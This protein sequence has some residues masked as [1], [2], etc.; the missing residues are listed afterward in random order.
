MAQK[1]KLLAPNLTT[2]V[3]CLCSSC[4]KQRAETQ[5]LSTD[6][7]ASSLTTHLKALE[8]K[9]AN[10]P[11]RSRRQEIIKLR[12]ED[13]STFKTQKYKTFIK[14]QQLIIY[15]LNTSQNKPSNKN[16]SYGM[17]QWQKLSLPLPITPRL[18]LGVAYYFMNCSCICQ[19]SPAASSCITQSKEC[20]YA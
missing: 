2:W 12:G 19:I 8:K 4:Y 7:H 17:Y 10:S 14:R 9:E 20:F 13:N 6:F 11:K 5:K 1:A 15:F 3:L 16:K 18:H